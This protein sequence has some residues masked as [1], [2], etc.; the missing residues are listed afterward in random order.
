MTRS[1]RLLGSLW[2]YTGNPEIAKF[3][4]LIPNKECVFII[5]VLS[6]RIVALTRIGTK[7]NFTYD[8]FFALFTEIK[9]S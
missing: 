2:L 8:L 4:D 7:A 5:K 1:N 3:D 9:Y 6:T